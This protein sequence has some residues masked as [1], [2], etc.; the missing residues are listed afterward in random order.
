MHIPLV[1]E[2]L[3][4]KYF[5]RRSADQATKGKRALLPMDVFILVF[6]SFDIVIDISY[7]LISGGAARFSNNSLDD[8]TDLWTKLI[9]VMNIMVSLELHSHRIAPTG[10]NI[11][12]SP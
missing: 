8:S 9:Q 3:F 11:F 2:H 5:V 1:Y 12:S 10:W 6:L 4:Y 7:I